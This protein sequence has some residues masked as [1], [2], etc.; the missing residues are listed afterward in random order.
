MTYI[1]K[2]LLLIILLIITAVLVISEI[3]KEASYLEFIKN[4]ISAE[5]KF[6][7]KKYLLPYKTI[8]SLEEIIKVIENTPLNLELRTKEKQE[9]I[10]FRGNRKI[11]IF[12]DEKKLKIFTNVDQILAGINRRTPGSAYLEFFQDKLILSSSSGIIAYS[13]NIDDENITFNQIKNNLNSIVNF[14]SFKKQK[15]RQ[16]FSIKDLLVFNNKIFV[17]YTNEVKNNCWNTSIAY[18]EMNLIEL[19]FKILFEPKECIPEES[20]LNEFNA[21]QSGGRMVSYDNDH[22]LFTTGEYRLRWKAQDKKSIFGKILK[23]NINERNYEIISMGHRNPQG[24]TF[25]KKNNL[26][27]ATE[28]GPRGGDEINLFKPK[29]DKIINFGWPIS[30]YGE[31]YNDE[32]INEKKYE[33]YPLKKSHK[34]YGF[35]EPL[36][37]FVPSIGI[38]EITMYDE[39]KYIFS[40]MRSKNLYTLT[41]NEDNSLKKIDTIVIGER[42]RDL[43]YKK[44]QKKIILFLEDT[45][46]I[47]IIENYKD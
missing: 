39:K 20:E 2:K 36:K 34:N 6:K 47:G 27:L 16:A 22:I 1:K 4:K 29:I 28:H 8:N 37:Y 13:N 35:V 9:K 21:H 11:N 45:A 42:I 40:S 3:G 41:L 5:T 12:N 19:N 38:S 7:I 43:I 32:K 31:H 23:I 25:D 10:V 33:L 24:L 30:S 14:E 17:S 44:E 18:A 15:M 46:S 26:I